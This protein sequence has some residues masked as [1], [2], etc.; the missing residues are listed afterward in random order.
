MTVDESQVGAS[1]MH[2]CDS[3][4]DGRIS[5]CSVVDIVEVSSFVCGICAVAVADLEVNAWSFD[6]VCL[7]DVAFGIGGPVS[8]RIAGIGPFIGVAPLK[9]CRVGVVVGGILRAGI[10][11]TVGIRFGFVAV[12]FEVVETVNPARP[13]FHFGAVA[14][15]VAIDRP[16]VLVVVSVHGEIEENLLEIAGAADGASF[17]HCGFQ[18][19]QKHTG[20]DCNDRNYHEEFYKREFADFVSADLKKI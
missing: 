17:V 3:V 9:F 7:Q 19:R 1:E 8:R 18:R 2:E 5:G 12:L 6:A 15:F 16:H 4:F 11:G 20:K 13:C 10:G 14:R